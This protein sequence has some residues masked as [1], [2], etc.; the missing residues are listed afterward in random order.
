MG[1]PREDALDIFDHAL[2]TSRVELAMERRVHFHGAVME[3]DGNRFALKEYQRCVVIALGKAAGTMTAALLRL[4]GREAE[5]FEGV[6]VS[7][8]EEAVPSRRFRCVRGGHPT[9]D[10]GSMMAAKEVLEALVALSEHDLVIF[11]VSGGGSALVE[12]FLDGETTLETMAATH[13]VLVESGAPITAINAVRKHLSAVKGG[14]LA[15]AAAPAEQLTIFVSDVPAGELDALSSGPTVPDRSTVQDVYRIVAEYHLAERLPAEVTEMLRRGRVPETPK[16]GET[17]FARSRWSVLLDSTSLERAA[18]ECAAGLGWSIQVDDTCDDWSA[19]KA[20]DY[21]V[22]RA[23]ELKKERGPVCLIS[24]GEVTVEVP[25]GARG[26]GGRNQHFALL[27]ADQIRGESMTVL[28]GGSD[29]I[30]GNSP[31]AGAVVDG[32]TASRAAA[33]GYPISKALA[34]FDSCSLLSMLG[35]A[36]ITGPTGNNLRDLRILLAKR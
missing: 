32:S 18:A 25:S 3:V 23:R 7:P 6:V 8:V 19:K 15:A 16:P 9:P 26:R 28:S 14:R 5:R 17:I 34:A 12:R 30:D 11:L 24:T 29:G 21:L 36:I 27:C 33:T 31:A 20:A 13:K 2:R 22:G 10:A 35:D 4:A 1:T